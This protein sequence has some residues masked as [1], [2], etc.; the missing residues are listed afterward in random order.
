MLAVIVVMVI[1]GL[2]LVFSL[3]WRLIGM[4]LMREINGLELF[5]LLVVVV[6]LQTAVFSGGPVGLIALALIWIIGLGS[7]IVNAVARKRKLRRMFA[8]DIAKY[9]EGLRRQPDVPFPHRRLGDI[10]FDRGDWQRAADHYQSYLDVHPINAY[11]AQR[12][13]RSLLLKRRQDMGLRTCAVCGAENAS[14]AA[15]CVACGFYLR[16]SREIIDVLTTPEMMR[17]WRW[18]MI[19]FLLPAVVLGFIPDGPQWVA[20]LMLLVSVIATILY[21]YARMTGSEGSN[22][23]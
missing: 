6:G 20:G 8:D 17:I 4:C 1:G 5:M 18:V 16:G 22:A 14:D 15:R 13:E 12:L 23:R 19:A 3:I 10:Y 21:I 9:E 2:F 7:P 11:C